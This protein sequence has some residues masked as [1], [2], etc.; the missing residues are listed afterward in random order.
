MTVRL[1]ETLA[2]NLNDWTFT[3]A[4]GAA[5]QFANPPGKHTMRRCGERSVPRFK[6]FLDSRH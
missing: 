4:T 2:R 3:Y 6:Q 5:S 1:D